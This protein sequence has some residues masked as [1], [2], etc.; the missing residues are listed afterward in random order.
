M[1]SPDAAPKFAARLNSFRVD[2]RNYWPG[3]NGKATTLD[4]IGRAA[5][6][7]GLNC[8]DLN[9]PDHLASLRRAATR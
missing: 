7:K 3:L 6:V 1:R 8:V 9:Y 4:V 2:E 5:K